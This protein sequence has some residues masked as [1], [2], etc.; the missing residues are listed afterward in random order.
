M[1]VTVR[2]YTMEDFNGLIDVQRE[3]F[4][5]PFPED[6][7]W[8]REQIAAHV[9]VFPEGALLA[10][11]NGHIVGSATS[12]IIHYDGSPHTWAEVADQGYIRTSHIPDGDSL[13][14]IDV[15]VRPSFRGKG[16]AKALYEA[17]KE[18]VTR[19]GLTRFLAGC[20]IPGFHRYADHMSA[21]EYVERVTNGEIY[22]MVLSFMI[23]QGLTPLQILD[24]Y[25]EDEE[26]LNKAVLVEWRNPIVTS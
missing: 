20:R 6:L 3:A 11:W 12:L 15:C 24:H 14:G 5:P 17:R 13:Y 10:E 23:K 4:P 9:E 19:L 16:I 18:L 7:W 1:S 2:P 25:V 21:A 8:S 22:D 26:S